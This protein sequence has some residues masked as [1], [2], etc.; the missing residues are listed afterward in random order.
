MTPFSAFCALFLL[1]FI[2]LSQAQTCRKQAI[3]TTGF[4]NPLVCDGDA[5]GS[6]LSVFQTSIVYEV[7][8][9]FGEDVIN[10]PLP[11]FLKLVIR[12]SGKAINRDTSSIEVDGLTFVYGENDAARDNFRLYFNVL[13]VIVRGFE[14]GNCPIDNKNQRYPRLASTRGSLLSLSSVFEV[15]DCS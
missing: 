10:V 5:G 13:Q 9:G 15:P 1:S 3:F 12:R 7:L 6:Q 11:S 4:A 8:G 2:S 14:T